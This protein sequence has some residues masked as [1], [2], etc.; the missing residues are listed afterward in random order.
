MTA[1]PRAVYVADKEQYVATRNAFAY[2]ITTSH[3][4]SSPQDVMQYKS[5]RAIESASFRARAEADSPR[6]GDAFRV[7]RDRAVR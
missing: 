3:R 7:D 1:R 2:R 6:D 5:D 4:R